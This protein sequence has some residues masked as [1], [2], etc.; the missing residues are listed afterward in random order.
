VLFPICRV[1]GTEFKGRMRDRIGLETPDD[2]ECEK[3]IV[4]Q[5]IE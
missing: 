4:Q 5:R 1:L 2:A 3:I